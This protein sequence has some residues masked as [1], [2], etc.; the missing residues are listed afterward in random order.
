M[1]RNP[2]QTIGQIL[3]V[4]GLA[5]LLGGV[6]WGSL[7]VVWAAPAGTAAA[8][9]IGIQA[10]PTNLSFSFTPVNPSAGEVVTFVANPGSPVGSGQITYTWNFGD[11]SAEGAG[12]SN[13]EHI[14]TLN[15]V[16]QVT[17]TATGDTCAPQPAPVTHL[18]TVGFGAPAAIIYLPLVAK[19][20][21]EIIFPT[22]RQPIEFAP[23]SIPVQVGDSPNK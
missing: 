10:C 21:P 1:E 12:Q 17:L 19:N 15:G 23:I 4:G 11:G 6:G 3:L 20:Y 2:F 16:Y 8:A 14:Y 5:L 18:I 13:V 22:S 7:A 9:Q